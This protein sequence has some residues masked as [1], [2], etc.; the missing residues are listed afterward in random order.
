MSNTR[1]TEPATGVFERL[2]EVYRKQREVS[3]QKARE[4]HEAALRHKPDL[5]K[6]S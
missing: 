5:S 2:A 3:V 6:V 4:E 1:S